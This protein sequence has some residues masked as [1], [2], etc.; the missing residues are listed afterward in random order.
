MMSPNDKGTAYRYLAEVIE[1]LAARAPGL[2]SVCSDQE[3]LSELTRCNV[4]GKLG[5]ITPRSAGK[6]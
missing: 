2:R 5:H 4:Q 3:P 1:V 6:R